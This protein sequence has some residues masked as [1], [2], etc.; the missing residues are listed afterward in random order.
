MALQ[1][2]RSNNAEFRNASLIGAQIRV[3]G[4]VQSPLLVGAGSAERLMQ[5][6]VRDQESLYGN[7]AQGILRDLMLTDVLGRP[8]EDG[9]VQIT[10]VPLGL[11]QLLTGGLM[12]ADAVRLGQEQSLQDIIQSIIDNDPNNYGPPPASKAAVEKLKKRDIKEFLGSTIECCV[13]LV[14][15]GDISEHDVEKMVGD[16]REVI[17]MPCDH[18]FHSACIIPWLKEHNSCPTCRFELPTDD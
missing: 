3:R 9:P 15:F 17:E 7:S 14:P 18:S 6:L 11:L 5:M 13:C 1:R 16:D 4:G 8:S 2:I 12:N 10:G